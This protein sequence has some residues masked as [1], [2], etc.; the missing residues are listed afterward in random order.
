MLNYKWLDG[1]WRRGFSYYFAARLGEQFFPQATQVG[2]DAGCLG[3]A[4][5]IF[6][7]SQGVRIVAA[8][9]RS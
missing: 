6:R 2:F 7:R 3:P 8:D 4:T 1:R 9:I 5:E